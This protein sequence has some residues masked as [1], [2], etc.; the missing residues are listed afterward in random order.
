[1]I[2]IS[3]MFSMI[4]QEGCGDVAS[5]LAM[6]GCVE[7]IHIPI[8][9]IFYLDIMFGD[10]C[11]FLASNIQEF[12]ALR[13]LAIDCG[14]VSVTIN[15]LDMDILS[16]VG[17][18]CIFTPS[19]GMSIFMKECITDL[20]NLTE[21]IAN[22]VLNLAGLPSS[23]MLNTEVL[24]QAIN[25][26]FEKLVDLI[27]ESCERCNINVYH[28]GELPEFYNEILSSGEMMEMHNMRA[29]LG[30]AVF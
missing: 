8:Y 28:W 13:K 11:G 1:M 12:T 16:L 5:S 18:V 19:T 24:A 2:Q 25:I 9:E 27:S 29:M 22:Q 4:G 6:Q 15:I 26:L 3:D 23:G 14:A 30:A 17:A 7:D 20:A 10:K 21:D